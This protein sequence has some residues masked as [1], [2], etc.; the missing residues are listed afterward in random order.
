MIREVAC[1]EANAKTAVA[2][3]DLDERGIPVIDE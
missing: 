3:A 1:I 2:R